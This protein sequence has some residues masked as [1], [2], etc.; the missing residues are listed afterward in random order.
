[1]VRHHILGAHGKELAMNQSPANC[2]RVFEK[3]N[4]PVVRRNTVLP[5]S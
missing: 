5:R 4:D 1:M 3:K 2:Q